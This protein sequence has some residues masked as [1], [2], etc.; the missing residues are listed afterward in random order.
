MLK[1]GLVNHLEE[2]NVTHRVECIGDVCATVR[3]G[4][5]FMLNPSVTRETN[6]RR[7]DTQECLGLKLCWE[8]RV[9]RASVRNGR[10]RRSKICTAGHS[11][12]IGRYEAPLVRDLSGFKIGIIVE[13]FQK[14]M[15]GGW[16]ALLPDSLRS[17]AQ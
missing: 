6:G 3:P 12:K 4:G 17:K 10:S 5:F 2:P 11:K 7:A 9:S 14:V 13:L 16:R 15:F 8:T 1:P